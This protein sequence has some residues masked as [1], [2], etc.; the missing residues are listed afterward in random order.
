MSSHENN[1]SETIDWLTPKYIIDA[2]P[3]FDLDPCS[4][5]YQEHST[6]NTMI[7]LPDDGLSIKWFGRVWLN[8]PY[9]A[10]L[11]NAWLRRM[12]SHNNGIALVFARTETLWFH[13][14]IWNY[15]SGLFFFKGRL[16]YIHAKAFSERSKYGAN[17][18]SPSVLVAYGS[19][20]NSL[21]KSVKLKG[22]YV[23]MS[24]TPHNTA[25]SGLVEGSGTLPAVVNQIEMVL[26]AVS[27]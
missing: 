12:A 20:C 21:L 4:S 27:R 24:H 15:C 1:K 9:G 7:R 26:P 3:P 10:N 8:P 2:F 23:D 16:S 5:Q 17:A 13:D 14:W 11:I 25:C 22:K 18:A 19:E 6:A